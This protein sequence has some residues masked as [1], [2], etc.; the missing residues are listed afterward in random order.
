[1]AKHQHE[2]RMFRAIGALFQIIQLFLNAGRECAPDVHVPWLARITPAG[3]LPISAACAVW[4]AL[5][6]TG[7]ITAFCLA[8]ERHRHTSRCI[9]LCSLSQGRATGYHSAVPCKDSSTTLS[10]YLLLIKHLR[11]TRR[12]PLLWGSGWTLDIQSVPYG[13]DSTACSSCP[14]YKLC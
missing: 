9:K 12:V 10:N 7:W 13:R 6:W 4:A 8:A 2:D 14:I 11:R 3:D 1:M 5:L